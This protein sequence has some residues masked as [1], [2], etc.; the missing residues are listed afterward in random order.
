MVIGGHTASGPV[1]KSW[2]ENKSCWTNTKITGPACGAL[3]EN[4]LVRASCQV[5]SET[6][7]IFNIV[8]FRNI[9]FAQIWNNRYIGRNKVE[10]KISKMLHKHT[11][12]WQGNYLLIEYL[13]FTSKAIKTSNKLTYQANI[14]IRWT[15]HPVTRF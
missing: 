15:N 8:L 5:T 2:R 7:L 1:S 4:Q 9:F 6:A 14:S 11:H 10:K 12:D 3:F 13:R